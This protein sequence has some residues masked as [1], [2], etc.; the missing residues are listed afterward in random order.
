MEIK[1]TFFFPGSFPD[2]DEGKKVSFSLL[3]LALD[4]HKMIRNHNFFPIRIS[5]RI[6]L[7]DAEVL[8]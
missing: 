1:K 5:H 3:P 4:V 6:S 2:A 8:K 7:G